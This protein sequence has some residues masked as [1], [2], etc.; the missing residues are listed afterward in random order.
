MDEVLSDNKSGNIVNEK[1]HK[2]LEDSGPGGPDNPK[3]AE[4]LNFDLNESADKI[5]NND[6]YIPIRYELPSKN[7]IANIINENNNIGREI[8]KM[9]EENKKLIKLLQSLTK[10]SNISNE[11]KK[12]LEAYISSQAIL[13]NEAKKIF[14]EEYNK[15]KGMEH[16]ISTL[17]SNNSYI[18]K[19][20]KEC[21]ENEFRMKLQSS[22]EKYLLH[23]LSRSASSKRLFSSSSIAALPKY[24]SHGNINDHSTTNINSNENMNENKKFIKY[25]SYGNIYDKKKGNKKQYFEKYGANIPLQQKWK[26]HE[27]S[28]NQQ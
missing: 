1:N 25:Y 11:K 27:E 12:S 16:E 2:I 21:R 23:S 5:K 26:R 7:E 28:C 8:Y 24:S 10:S 15:M 22:S 6:N 13:L 9:N 3:Q 20:L 17:R 18:K 4:K 19:K 14:I